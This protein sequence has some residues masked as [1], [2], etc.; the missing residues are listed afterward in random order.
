MKQSI[1][2]DSTKLIIELK[3]DEEKYPGFVES[4]IKIVRDRGVGEQVVLKSFN[5]DQLELCR[6]L[7]PEIERL[8][9]FVL[10]ASW[11]NF[12]IGTS[13]SFK[14]ILEKNPAGATYYQAHRW[15]LTK[16]F[17]EK[18]QEKGIRLIA[19]H[20]H[21]HKDIEAVLEPQ[22]EKFVLFKLACQS[23]IGLV[24]ELGNPLGKYLPV[25]F[26][27]NVH[28]ESPAIAGMKASLGILGRRIS[29][30]IYS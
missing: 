12:T 13:P 17:V 4:I 16:S 9:V 18:V 7:A 20:V 26:V 1:L 15:F 21:E 24:T 19:W 29:L 30:P 14:D 27:I 2:P 10:H 28:R 22:R 5:T 8:Y 11:L 23:P 25:V 3:G 6:K